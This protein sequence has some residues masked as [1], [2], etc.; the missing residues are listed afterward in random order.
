MYLLFECYK[1]AIWFKKFDDY[2]VKILGQIV[3][4]S[5]TYFPE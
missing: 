4:N 3:E 5:S 1:N 2:T